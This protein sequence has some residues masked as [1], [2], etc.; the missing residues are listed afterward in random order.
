M[1]NSQ[2]PCKL[3]ALTGFSA[4]KFIRHIK[5]NKAKEFLKQPELTITA[6]AFD[7]GFKDPSYFGR[8]LKQEFGRRPQEWR[9]RNAI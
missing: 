9:E 3:S 7:T 4:T 1:S 6:V 5:L 8:V 2:L